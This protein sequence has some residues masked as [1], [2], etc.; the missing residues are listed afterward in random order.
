MRSSTWKHF[1]WQ[2]LGLLFYLG[3]MLIFLVVMVEVFLSEPERSLANLSSAHM[4]FLLVSVLLIVFGRY[5]GYR[6]GGDLTDGMAGKGGP[7][8]RRDSIL[9]DYGYDPSHSQEDDDDE[10]QYTYEDDTVFLRCPDCGEKN[11]PE[12]DYCGNC[13]AK[14]EK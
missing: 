3:G 6:F 2:A 4:P 12:F 9:E 13:A 8:S 1:A 5:I 14:L 7:Q 10:P 11:E